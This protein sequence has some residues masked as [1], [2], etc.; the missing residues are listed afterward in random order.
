MYLDHTLGIAESWARLMEADRAGH[1]ELLE[2]TREPR[3]WERYS[4][5]QGERWLKPDARVRFARG[6]W[7]FLLALEIDRASEGPSAIRRKLDGYIEHRTL[8]PAT[9]VHP[10]PLVLF[11]VPDEARHDWMMKQL[12]RLPAEHWAQFLV[13]TE[14]DFTSCLTRLS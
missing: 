1:V 8:A 2:F 6:G 12:A 3:C 13:T 10:H 9:T 4:G 11:V 5:L 14:A 7:E